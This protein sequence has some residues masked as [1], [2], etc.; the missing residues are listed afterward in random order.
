MYR[1][2]PLV[3]TVR[4]TTVKEHISMQR[5]ANPIVT[6]VVLALLALPPA[7]VGSVVTCGVG[8]I[9]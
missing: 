4:S 7:S 5:K 6:F 3:F 2:R 1:P 9:R 8:E